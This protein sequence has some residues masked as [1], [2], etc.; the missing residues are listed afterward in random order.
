[1]ELRQ[2]MIF[3]KAAETLNFTKAGQ[4]LDYAQS[5]I[6]G[7]IRLLEEELK[8]K[9]FERLGRNIK[10]TSEGREFYS[11]AKHIIDLSEEA[12][13]RFS[14][15]DY[16]GTL[17]IGAAETIC[18]YYLPQ[19]LIK[20]RQLYPQVKICIHMDA[21]DQFMERL[22]SNNIDVA[23]VLTNTIKMPELASQEL[24]REEMATVV[25]PFHHMASRSTI[26]PEDFEGES[27]IITLPGCGYRPL[28]LA[29]LEEHQINLG[30]I[31]ELSSV[32]S[33]KQCTIAGLGIAVV[34]KISVKNE[35]LQG[36]LKELSLEGANLDVK[37]FLV[38]HQKKWLSPAIR[39]F[40]AL[41]NEN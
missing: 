9:L 5:N 31:I 11:Y 16:K 34:P 40:L 23:M 15:N 20:Y 13:N 38:Y 10:L 28:I 14:T 39:G 17:N 6:T 41:C 36:T 21:C 8:V 27:L 35:L 2:L 33:I 24:Q 37:N 1:M 4:Y 25:S 26:T 32:A 7:Q 30:S 3:C 19:L 22:K 18:V 29:L 12:K